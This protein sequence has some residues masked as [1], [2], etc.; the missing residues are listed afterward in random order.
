M[1]RYLLS[2]VGKTV[3]PNVLF[4]AGHGPDETP[5]TECLP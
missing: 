4:A 5:I 3:L 1:W 2:D